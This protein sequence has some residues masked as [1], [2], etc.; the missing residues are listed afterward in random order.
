M[1]HRRL[2]RSGTPFRLI[3]KPSPKMLSYFFKQYKIFPNLTQTYDVFKTKTI[4]TTNHSW[5]HLFPL[6]F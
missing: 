5:S 3:L 4:W 6:I 1:K 2:P